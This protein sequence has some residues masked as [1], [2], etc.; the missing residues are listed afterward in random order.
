LVDRYAAA[1]REYLGTAVQSRAGERAALL[2]RAEVPHPPYFPSI[3]RILVAPD[4][5]IWVERI[6]IA[7]DALDLLWSGGPIPRR[8]SGVWDAFAPDGSFVATIDFGSRFSPLK[9]ENGSLLGI[10][11]TESGV[12]R[13]A[14]KQIA[15]DRQ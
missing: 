8:T 9:A 7:D 2:A 13:V 3:G 1:V 14:R 5:T 6:D 11:R 10:L 15:F 12:H 4:G